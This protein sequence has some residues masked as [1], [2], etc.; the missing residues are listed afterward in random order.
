MTISFFLRKSW[1][2]ACRE[3]EGVG[4]EDVKVVLVPAIEL[5][6]HHHHVHPVLHL[7]QMGV[8]LVS[9]S[10]TG[11]AIHEVVA[12]TNYFRC[13]DSLSIRWAGR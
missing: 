6:H 13:V 9:H 5:A 4:I 2:N 1:S 10:Q 11:V 12:I 7:Q 8:D 3:R